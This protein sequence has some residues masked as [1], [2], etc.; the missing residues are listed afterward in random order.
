MTPSTIDRKRR[1][2]LEGGSRLWPVGKDAMK[3]ILFFMAA[4]LF[5]AAT[6]SHAQVRSGT[7]QNP[8]N[9]NDSI[10]VTA[11]RT[12]T[13]L[14][15]I[16][17][18]ITVISREEIEKSQSA[19]VAHIL[20]NV[21]GLD[22]VQSGGAGKFTSVFIRGANTHHTLVLLDGIPLNDPSSP[23]N[24]ANLSTL[25]TANIERI[26]ILRGPQSVLYGPEAIGGVI[27]I[28][29]KAGESAKN[30]SV[31]SEGGSFDTYN[32]TGNISGSLDKL[33]Y[34]LSAERFKTNGISSAGESFGGI[35][36]DGYENTGLSSRLDY[37]LNQL[38]R[39]N[40]T[41]R[42]TD[43]KSDLDKTGAP[44]DDP[45]FITSQKEQQYSV[46][47]VRQ[48]PN[49]KS[50]QQLLFYLGNI[51]RTSS[52][53]F[54]P[55]HPSDSEFTETTGHR[56]GAS[57]QQTIQLNRFNS[58]SAG[59]ETE[60]SSFSSDLF[61]RSMFGD[62][63]DHVG[64]KT[65]WTRGIFV[66]DQLHIKEKVFLTLGGRLDEHKQFGATGTYRFTA[67]YLL[68]KTGTRFRGV[69]GTGYKAPS[70]FQL[71][72]P[73]PYIGNSN[74]VPEKSRGWEIGVE[75]ELKRDVASV[76]VTYFDNNFEDLIV[77]IQ[78]VA[79]AT[80]NGIEA[81]LDLKTAN[82]LSRLDY[83]YCDSKDKSSE[84]V[85]IRRP[86]HKLVLSAEY[87]FT[88]R[89]FLNFTARH[90]GSREDLDFSQ[91]PSPRVALKEYTVVNLAGSYLINKNLEITGR[92]DNL[93]DEEYQE[94][95]SYGNIPLSVHAGIKLSN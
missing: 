86:K 39:F 40:L 48:L 28:F 33:G 80:S 57:L 79:E 9:L 12:P 20:R 27:Q 43:S 24:A 94:V 42:F 52:D 76:S 7:E 14:A 1:G 60:R 3:R 26:E 17:S 73:S 6:G 58:F 22:V 74:L 87:K 70:V 56:I 32:L 47:L 77:G 59:I 45:N 38:L 49:S 65:S 25:M 37:S 61:F 10:A 34:A 85:L 71:Y 84:D 46:R 29:S 23:N 13:P 82:F 81:S 69:I 36:D 75:Q 51:A 4:S 64:G 83:T 95:Y 41:G 15:E 62:F 63:A 88:D 31:S 16:A 93:F 67:A 44:F 91:F 92:V 11:N 68:D 8:I 19:F 78:N 30:V 2:S 72:H 21:P 35:E 53:I 90:T 89:L 18:S 50:N 55:A 66:F 54:D 5:V